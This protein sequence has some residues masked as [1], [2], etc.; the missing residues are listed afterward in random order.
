[1]QNETE[2]W[3]LLFGQYPMCGISQHRFNNKYWEV[4]LHMQ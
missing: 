1:M 4:Q 2:I 3:N